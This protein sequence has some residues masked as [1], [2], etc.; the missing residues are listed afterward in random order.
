[1]LEQEP[2]LL[3]AKEKAIVFIA[4]D[5][6]WHWVLAAEI[7]WFLKQNADDVE[8]IYLKL[9]VKNNLRPF[10]SKILSKSSAR[11]NIRS[12]LNSSG[13]QFS[14]CSILFSGK[15]FFIIGDSEKNL[16]LE[17]EIQ[18]AIFPDLVA[19]IQTDIIP[20]KKYKAKIRSRMKTYQ[21]SSRAVRTL[22]ISPV[23]TIYVINERF[24]ANRA[25]K[26]SLA[27]L[28]FHVFSLDL[29]GRLDR[30]HIFRNSPSS[31]D[32]AESKCAETWLDGDPISRIQIADSY[33]KERRIRDPFYHTAWTER[34]TEDSLPNLD[35]LRKV[36]TFYSSSQYEFA[37]IPQKAGY[38]SSEF[39]SQE[40]ALIALLETLDPTQWQVFLRRH[41]I[42]INGHGHWT[43]GETKL[44]EKFLAY[45]HLTVIDPDS[46]VDSFALAAASDLAVHFNSSIGPE[47][48]HAEISKVL[49][50]GPTMWGYLDP[51]GHIRSRK[52]L[53]DRISNLDSWNN[54]VDIHP[55]GYFCAVG[56]VPLAISRLD[57]TAGV[58]YVAEN[59]VNN[60]SLKRTL[61]PWK[62]RS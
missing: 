20:I 4:Y 12:F 26:N 53:E 44:W 7:A 55:W 57:R 60:P 3:V 45:P 38:E 46:S 51:Y 36:C 14:E 58:W 23:N 11:E 24:S 27:K 8:V 50:M 39:P 33:F 42:P 1:M 16:S 59:S 61:L 5:M 48:I 30:F 18:A 29:S 19:S 34:F 62:F 35:P 6:N 56:G 32:E 2:N 43:D 25:I 22:T 28:G 21:L 37:G 41:P 40:L 31:L 47:L 9:G 49:T 54:C 17:N 15:R 52:E 13:I 10:I